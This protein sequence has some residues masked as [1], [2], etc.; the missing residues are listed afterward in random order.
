MIWH[1]HVHILTYDIKVMRLFHYK[2]II[3]RSLQIHI[4]GDRRVVG[5]SHILVFYIT[6]YTTRCRTNLIDHFYCIIHLCQS[7]LKLQLL[8]A[9]TFHVVSETLHALT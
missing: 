7:K 5:S 1:V 3:L 2:K 8:F 4:K 9:S 6:R